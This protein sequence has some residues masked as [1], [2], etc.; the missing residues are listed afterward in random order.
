MWR[1]IGAAMM[2]AGAMAPAVAAE[3]LQ[4]PQLAGWKVI[5]NVADRAGE[6]TELI[7]EAEL[8]DTWSRRV[9]IQAFRGVAMT[10]RAFL[11]QVVEKTVAVCDAAAAGQPSLGTVA[12]AEAGSRTVAC[13]R[14]KGDG[15]GSYT[16]YYVIR[17]SEAFYVVSRSWRGQPFPAGSTPV[18][19]D[20]L[21]GWAA[22]VDALDLCD[23][24]DPRRPCR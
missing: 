17:G 5:A 4:V 21:T 8:A 3:R 16:L 14:Y 24:K 20:E 2:M 9:T 19:P 13:G 11:D 12:G 22:Y 1:L 23:T 15:K 7:P 10:V 6:V 18:P